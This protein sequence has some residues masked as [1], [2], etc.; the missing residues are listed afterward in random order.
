MNFPE[1]SRPSPH[2]SANPAHEH[3]GVCFH[4]SVMDF[5]ST[6]AHMRNPA[7][8]VSYHILIAPDGARAR[9]VADE[10]VA[11]HAGVSSFQGRSRCNDFL[12][13]VSFAGDTRASPLTA[14]QVASALDW[15]APRWLRHNWTAAVMTDHR[16][17][18]PGR[19]DD[20]APAEWNRLITA[21]T[22]RFPTVI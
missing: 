17:I 11:W 9:L 7:S 10:H 5:E 12:L 20:L 4:H 14:A 18:A 3:L 22:E 15:L 6:I 21:I 1:S 8:E 16:Q 19:K 13:G 2:F